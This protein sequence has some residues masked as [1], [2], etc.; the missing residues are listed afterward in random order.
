MTHGITLEDDHDA[1]VAP[2][3]E[4]FVDC[5]QV[6]VHCETMDEARDVA[7]SIATEYDIEDGDSA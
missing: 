4:G 7:D 6:V 5:H 2:E 1:H 3:K